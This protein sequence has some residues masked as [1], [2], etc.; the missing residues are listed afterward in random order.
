MIVHRQVWW[1]TPGT[2]DEHV[3]AIREEDDAVRALTGAEPV[4]I[5]VP[6]LAPHSVIAMEW[7]AESLVAKDGWLEAWA[8]T[9]RVLAFHK[10]TE[11]LSRPDSRSTHA[12]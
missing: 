11:S 9:G 4:R 3:K 6:F 5:Y 10:H 8:K 12:D 7:T 1:V 2:I